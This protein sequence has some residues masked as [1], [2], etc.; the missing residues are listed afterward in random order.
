M[1][2][3]QTVTREDIE[4]AVQDC[5]ETIYEHQHALWLFRLVLGALVVGVGPSVLT[6]AI[7]APFN[8]LYLQAIAENIGSGATV[9]SV[10][11]ALGLGAWLFADDDLRVTIGHYREAKRLLKKLYR[12]LAYYDEAAFK[13]LTAEQYM[14]QLP[15]LI[16]SYRKRA[17]TYRRWFIVLQLITIFLSAAITSLSGGWLD[18]YVSIPW[19]IPVLGALISILTSFTLFFKLR[20]K[21]TNLQQTA[22]TMDWEHLACTLGIGKYKGLTDAEKYVLLAETAEQL[23]QEQQKR[24]LQLEQ[25]SHT[26]QKALQSAT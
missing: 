14:H 3:Q 10:L 26:E 4:D 16:K 22:D 12:Q 6:F 25:S 21:G 13:H 18:K 9:V 20:E 8:V 19:V 7:I 24:Q 11:L 23:R 17:D 2:Q 15:S 5:K 1:Q